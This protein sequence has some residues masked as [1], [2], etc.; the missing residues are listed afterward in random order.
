[1]E[2]QSLFETYFKKLEACGVSVEACNSLRDKYGDL[3]QI[4]SYN[5]TA[6]SGLAYEG[7]LIETILKK[8]TAFAVK[9]NEIYPEQIAVNKFSLVKVCLLQH[10]SKAVRL[11][12]S[13]DEWRRN[14]LGELYTYTSGMPAIGIGLHSLIMATECGIDFTP[15]EAEA[16]TII[17]R[18][19]DD[20]QAKYYS[21]ML[22]NIVKQAN[23]MVY[24]YSHEVQKIKKLEEE[25]KNAE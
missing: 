19:D 12:K 8:L 6:D 10:I 1:M 11:V 2:K 24:T 21:S 3:L 17:D 16:M 22:T 4:A 9:V 14:K 13:T 23:E 25:T 18:K 7:S 5:T 20:A 15:F